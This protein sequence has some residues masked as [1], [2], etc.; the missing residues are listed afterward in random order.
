MAYE[1]KNYYKQL[2][3]KE[4]AIKN[5]YNDF[6]Y[7]DILDRFTKPENTDYCE[8]MTE[9]ITYALG[10]PYDY[11]MGWE[12]PFLREYHSGLNWTCT[13]TLVGL[14]FIFLVEDNGNENLIG[15]REQECRKGDS[16]YSFLSE[17]YRSLVIKKLISTDNLVDLFT[18]AL[19]LC[20][21][22]R[23]IHGIGMRRL[24]SLEQE[25]Q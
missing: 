10:V 14:F 25:I 5:R 22:H 16:T 18:K 17:D 6:S 24:S 21:H 7:Q 15:I 12:V 20:T 9:G 1:Y 23:L 2:A 3:E 8:V 4:N 11:S 19:L 13:D